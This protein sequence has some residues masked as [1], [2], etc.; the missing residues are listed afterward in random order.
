MMPELEYTRIYEFEQKL[1]PL[2]KK[3]C[4]ECRGMKM[5]SVPGLGLVKCSCGGSGKLIDNDRCLRDRG[6]EVWM[7][8]VGDGP[9]TRFIR[10]DGTVLHAEVLNDD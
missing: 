9:R 6:Y 1:L 2:E 3:D 8:R 5:Y 4:P 10:R 7:S